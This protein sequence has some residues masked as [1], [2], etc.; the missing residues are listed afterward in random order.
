MSLVGLFRQIINNNPPV[1][2][3]NLNVFSGRHDRNE[4]NSEL[5]IESLLSSRIVSIKELDLSEN[6]SWFKH[7]QTKEERSGNTALLAELITKQAGLQQISLGEG[8]S[9]LYGGNNFTSNAI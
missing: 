2:V 3:L 4:N 6:S 1:E 7:P 9:G 5:V 8:G